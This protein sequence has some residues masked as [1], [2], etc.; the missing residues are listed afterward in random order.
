LTPTNPRSDGRG[1]RVSSSRP[2]HPLEYA[3]GVTRLGRASV[4]ALFV[5]GGLLAA[6]GCGSAANDEHEAEENEHFSNLFLLDVDRQTIRQLT[7]NHEEEQIVT[8]PSWS[9]DGRRIAFAEIPCEECPSEIRVLELEEERD[10]IGGTRIASGFKPSFSPDGQSIAFVGRLGRIFTM[11]PDGSSVHLLLGGGDS[12]DE[13]VWSPDGMRIAFTDQKNSQIYSIRRTG[14][15]LRRLTDGKSTNVNPA[16]SPARDR[17]ALARLMV[18]GHWQIH[19]MPAA[20]GPARPLSQGVGSDT[21][22][23]WSPDGTRLAFIRTIAESPSLFV[24]SASGAAGS[25]R[26][27]PPSIRASDPAWSPNGEQIAFVAPGDA[28]DL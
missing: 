27:L 4:V 26:L 23:T 6:L 11:R 22:P 25:R 18:R 1:N 7:G 19:V 14:G 5:V 9:P 21:S 12:Y 10:G 28:S 13:P 16:W 8:H 24:M 17:L 15:G 20:G 3:W 2:D